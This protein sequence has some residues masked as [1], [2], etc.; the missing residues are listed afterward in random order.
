MG[1]YNQLDILPD[2]R[3]LRLLITTSGKF[4]LTKINASVHIDSRRLD[5]TKALNS[6]EMYEC[7][8]NILLHAFRGEEQ[9]ATEEIQ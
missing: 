4:I 3:L 5:L 9:D 7:L 2:S 1:V 6:E 8:S